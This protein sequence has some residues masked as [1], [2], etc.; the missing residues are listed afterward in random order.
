MLNA[1]VAILGGGLS[2]VYAARLLN[3][4]G[5]SFCLFEARSALGGRL[6]SL[7]PEDMT[8][9]GARAKVQPDA[10]NR[11][12]LGATWFWPGIQPQLG[13]LIAELRLEVFEQPA[14]GDWLVERSRSAPPG[15]GRGHPSWP[16]SMRMAGGMA[17]LVD[18]LS[19]K[20]D[21]NRLKVAHQVVVIRRLARGVTV[22]GLAPDGPFTCHAEQ[23]L[24]AVPPRLAAASLSFDP[25]L[26]DGL[27][28]AWQAT[29]TWMAPHAKYL[30]VFKAP[31]WRE[32]GL[33]G[34]AQSAIGPMVE[35]HDASSPGGHA[36]LFGFIGVPAQVRAGVRRDELMAACRAQLV[37]LFGTPAAQ[38]VAETLQDWARELHTATAADLVDAG[39]AHAPS[40]TVSDGPWTGRMFGAASEWSPEYA[41]YVAGAIDAAQRSVDALRRAREE[42]KTVHGE[43]ET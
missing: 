24:L 4:L 9:T 18:A 19:Q 43:G 20:L 40:G 16:P 23:V 15:R 31:F 10:N 35:V 3:Q 32:H 8:G 34:S 33:A 17:S 2:G 30:A 1:Q 42:H 13:Q 27:S 6:L 37:R 5:L 21:P 22:E 25:P 11:F 7:S 39:H 26:P 41:G 29:P 28:R 12:D 38:P 36:A 14:K